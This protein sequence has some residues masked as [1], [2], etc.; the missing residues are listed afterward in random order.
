[1]HIIS[2]ICLSIV[3]ALYL[4]L[5]DP[6]SIKDVTQRIASRLL[7]YYIPNDEGAIPFNGLAD[8]TG[9]PWYESGIMWMTIADHV[10]TSGFVLPYQGTIQL[11]MLWHRHGVMR[12][13]V[14]R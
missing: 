6:A 8:A 12:H 5:S 7:D 2:C 10:K 13:M 11:V 1:M 4:N 3:H 9:I 14:L